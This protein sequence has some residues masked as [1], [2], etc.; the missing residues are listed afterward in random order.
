MIFIMAA[1]T[2]VLFGAWQDSHVA[3][4]FMFGFLGTLYVA[5]EDLL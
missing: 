1:V 3:G 5:L 2:S 4:T